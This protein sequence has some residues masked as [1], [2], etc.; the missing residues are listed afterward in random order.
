MRAT[1]LAESEALSAP[2]RSPP[3][4][5]AD[6]AESFLGRP[7][8]QG[9]RLTASDQPSSCHAIHRL[10]VA[11]AVPRSAVVSP[12]AASVTVRLACNARRSVSRYPSPCAQSTPRA[13]RRA[14][15]E[16]RTPP[17]QSRGTPASQRQRRGR[18][19]GVERQRGEDP[20]AEL[21]VSKQVGRGDLFA[22]DRR[23]GRMPGICTADPFVLGARS[24]SRARAGA[25][26][27]GLHLELD[28][29]VHEQPQW[30]L[31]CRS[32][33]SAARCAAAPRR[34]LG[35]SARTRTRG[36]VE[37]DLHLTAETRASDRG[38]AAVCARPGLRRASEDELG[39]QGE[40]GQRDRAAHTS[41]RDDDIPDPEE[42]GGCGGGLRRAHP[43]T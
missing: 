3:R 11:I 39:E 4:R 34:S 1:T 26:L 15:E 30:S 29:V 22:A 8:G 42:E 20:R 10:H 27:T 23:D 31:R 14:A 2:S 36:A 21:L 18:R 43:G 35:T 25:L 32:S 16:D 6:L 38:G 7:P 37:K 17:G 24:P 28:G 33:K 5:K 40:Y 9:E 13:R 19:A 12:A 41:L